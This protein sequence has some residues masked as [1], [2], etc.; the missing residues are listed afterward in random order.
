MVGWVLMGVWLMVT[1]VFPITL[2]RRAKVED[3][4]LREAFPED[5]EKWKKD[6]PCLLV[7]GVY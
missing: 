4:M 3:E 5:F 6:T 7:P 2:M 1:V